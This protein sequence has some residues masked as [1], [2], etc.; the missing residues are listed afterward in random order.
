MAR[1]FA[2]EHFVDNGLAVQ[3]AVHGAGEDEENPHCHILISTRRLGADGFGL[4]AR[5]LHPEVCRGYVTEGELWG[6][7]WERHQNRYFEKNGIGLKVDAI[8][9]HPT[10]HLG[11]VRIRKPNTEIPERA[12]Q[13]KQANVAAVRPSTFKWEKI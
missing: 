1:S 12:E 8:G 4:K 7:L 13:L 9:I 6:Q 11:P 3:F 2:Q 10:E 5:D